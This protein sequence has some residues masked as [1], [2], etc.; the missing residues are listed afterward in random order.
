MCFWA[1]EVA[2]RDQHA[3]VAIVR[4]GGPDLLA[5]DDP[6]VAVA[7][8][9]RAQAGEVGAGGRLGEE[10]A[11]DLLAAQRLAGVAVALRLRAPGAQRRDA[12]AE[13]DVEQAARHGVLRFLLVVDHL[14]DGGAA[15]PAPV[16]RPG[17]AGIAGV[18]LLGLPVL[19]P[20]AELGIL[21]AGA[22]D[23]AGAGLAPLGI[24]VQEGADA[25]AELGFL[26]GVFEVHAVLLTTGRWPSPA[27]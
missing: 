14:L 7:L 20:L 15:A 12:H 26:G 1:R 2:A 3:E 13:A 5:V 6:V 4:A 22:I 10:L 25:G 17:D 9:A 27:G 23:H 19:G 24:L 11:P 21:V 8:R 18:G 16:L